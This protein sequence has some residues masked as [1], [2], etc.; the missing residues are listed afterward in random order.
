M[1]VLA[2]DLIGTIT[3]PMPTAYQSLTGTNGGLILFFTNIL[4]LVFV[5]AG[6]YALINFIT[7]GYQFMSAGGDSKAINQAWNRILFSLVGLIVIV[8]SFALAAL[9]SKLIFGDAGYILNPQ[10][11][12]PGK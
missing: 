8:G 10:L 9:F 4:R 3:N 11:Y 1:N 7:A 5:V 2:D 12:G 6:I